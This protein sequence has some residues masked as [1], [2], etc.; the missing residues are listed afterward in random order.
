MQTRQFT[1]HPDEAIGDST[2][3]HTPNT[4]A[5]Y[6]VSA[7]AGQYLDLFSPVN[8]FI[9]EKTRANRDSSFSPTRVRS[10]LSSQTFA[11]DMSKSKVGSEKKAT[12]QGP[13]LT[14]LVDSHATSS[15]SIHT[16]VKRNVAVRSAHSTAR[17]S[18]LKAEKR[19]LVPASVR[20]RRTYRTD[21]VETVD[22]TVVANAKLL[23]ELRQMG[24]RTATAHEGSVTKNKSTK[25]ASSVARHVK[26]SQPP[27][28]HKVM[29]VD[30][31]HAK[32]QGK[33]QV[34]GSGGRWP[35][36][37]VDEPSWS[38][39]QQDDIWITSDEERN[40]FARRVYGIDRPAARQTSR[41]RMDSKGAV[42]TTQA[43]AG[44]PATV[45]EVPLPQTI[46]LP[47]STDDYTT[48]LSHV[49]PDGAFSIASDN[50][51]SIFPR[52]SSKSP[53]KSGEESRKTR[54]IPRHHETALQELASNAAISRQTSNPWSKVKQLRGL[55]LDSA[56][57]SKCDNQ[58]ETDHA[59][60]PHTRGE[61]CS[62][63][64]ANASNVRAL[65]GE[66]S[67]MKGEILALR[68]MLRRH[69]IPTPAAPRR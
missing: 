68:A 25:N 23:R 60:R 41:S 24:A 44:S 26:Q 56:V 28:P 1:I 9:A 58:V 35:T 53:N 67:H 38:E 39:E 20:K 34:F 47:T 19:R 36:D 46:G 30:A 57:I 33:M 43:P 37:S 4:Q 17:G 65:E 42:S 54:E 45:P 66:V 15:S 63:C 27:T 18:P 62:G 49:S 69:G 50:I 16:G 5:N 12:I 61:A 22:P 2:V 59:V 21:S 11:R 3:R 14:P 51:R 64:T 13:V 40:K 29:V 8:P 10:R 7:E 6:M 48:A 52:T 31:P 32:A 55:P